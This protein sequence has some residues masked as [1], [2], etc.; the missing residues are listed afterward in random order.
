MNTITNLTSE[1][2]HMFIAA[3]MGDREDEDYG[4]TDPVDPRD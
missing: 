3:A 1:D 4:K 2:L